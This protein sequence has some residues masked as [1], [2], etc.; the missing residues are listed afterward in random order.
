MIHGLCVKKGAVPAH[1]LKAADVVQK[2]Q[3]PRQIQ[4]SSGHAETPGDP[5]AEVR[6]PER[7]LNFKADHGIFRVI[8]GGISAKRFYCCISVEHIPSTFHPDTGVLSVLPAFVLPVLV[9]SA[10]VLSAIIA[11][12]K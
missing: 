4:Q 6:D 1:L 9:L 10:F 3:K 8:P 7:M 12:T 11:Q 2:A 5:P